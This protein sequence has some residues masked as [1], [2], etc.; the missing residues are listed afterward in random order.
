MDIHTDYV[1]QTLSVNAPELKKYLNNRR[2]SNFTKQPYASEP[3]DE[4]HEELNKRR[5]NMQNVRTEDFKQSFQLVDHY[6]QMK[7]SCFKDYEIKMHGGNVI[8]N[9]DYEEN[10][11]KIRVAMRRQSYVTKPYKDNGIFSL[12]D[13]ELNNELPNLVNIA[14]SQ[15]QENI[16]N[17]IRHNDFNSGYKSNSNFKVLKNKAEDKLGIDYETQLKI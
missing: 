9:Q 16:L 13:K 11:S 5:L 10:I 6:N 14:K 15:R 17:V 4:R 12:E 7:E 8:T 1:E 2:C 3:H